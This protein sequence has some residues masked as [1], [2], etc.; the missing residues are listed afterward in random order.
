[1]FGLERWFDGEWVDEEIIV[2]LFVL[3][4]RWCYLNELK[5]KICVWCN[6]YDRLKNVLIDKIR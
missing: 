6:W 1:M 4:K 2:T 5:I 3:K